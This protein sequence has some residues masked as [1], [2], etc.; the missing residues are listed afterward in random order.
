MLDLVIL[1]S[2]TGQ[3]Q[4][5]EVDTKL[6]TIGFVWCTKVSGHTIIIGR[7]YE[8]QL[9]LLFIN[10]QVY[11]SYSLIFHL[12]PVLFPVKVLLC[13]LVA[14]SSRRV[15]PVVTS[16]VRAQT[17]YPYFLFSRTLYKTLAPGYGQYKEKS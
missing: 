7:T 14:Q 15:E 17:S 11:G 4:T 9:K 5:T 10:Q 8:E 3:L 6:R 13:E 1:Y 2:Q 12:F 16:Q